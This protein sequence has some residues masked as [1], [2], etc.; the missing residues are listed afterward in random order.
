MSPK[1]FGYVM[2]LLLFIVAGALL[3]SSC[4]AGKI[5]GK[6]VEKEIEKAYTYPKQVSDYEQKCTTKSVRGSDGKMKTKREC[7]R[8]K[9]G[10]HTVI[11]RVP[12][13]YEI[14]VEGKRSGETCVSREVYEEL[15]IGDKFVGSERTAKSRQTKIG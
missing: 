10:S 15:E 1:R 12:T 7:N 13:C 9:V 5:E 6:V 11:Y 3:L 8:V 2:T 4:A 14:E